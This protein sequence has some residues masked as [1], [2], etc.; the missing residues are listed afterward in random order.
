MGEKSRQEDKGLGNGEIWGQRGGNIY[1]SLAL[2]GLSI[3]CRGKSLYDVKTCQREI[4]ISLF[5]KLCH[6]DSFVSDMGNPHRGSEEQGNGEVLEAFHGWSM[7][8][9]RKQGKTLEMA[10]I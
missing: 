1:Q 4:R 3:T 8:I 10:P 5:H 2:I 7:T 9:F 6:K